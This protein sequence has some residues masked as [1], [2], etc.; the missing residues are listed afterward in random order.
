MK[1]KDVEKWNVTREKGMLAFVLKNGILSWGVPMFIVMSFIVNKPF[2]DGFS[3]KNVTIH[4][5]TWLGAG[6]F[7]GVCT[8]MVIEKMY[9]KE[10][11]N[12]QD[13]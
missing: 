12:R 9:K 7:F 3:I 2:A 6:I 11:K 5:G 4:G 10:L 8:W 1:D 13:S